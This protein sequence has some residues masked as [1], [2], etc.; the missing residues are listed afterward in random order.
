M[1]KDESLIDFGPFHMDIALKNQNNYYP[2]NVNLQN[3]EQ[4]MSVPIPKIKYQKHR[5]LI[6]AS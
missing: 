6:N 3:I 2:T 5:K 1:Q 4:R